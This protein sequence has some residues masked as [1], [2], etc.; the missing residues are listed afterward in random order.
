MSYHDY[1]S[2]FHQLLM[3][4]VE[5]YR[6]IYTISGEPKTGY[7]QVRYKLPS[8]NVVGNT[9]TVKSRKNGWQHAP[10]CTSKR[11][12]SILPKAQA[13][14]DIHRVNNVLTLLLCPQHLYSCQACNVDCWLYV[15]AEQIKKVN[16]NNQFW[17][18]K[19]VEVS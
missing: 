9:I 16:E 13:T 5:K 1:L 12:S 8:L 18:K 4:G 6:I 14:G 11:Q 10:E 19:L 3:V 17:H 15:C 2:W 7:I